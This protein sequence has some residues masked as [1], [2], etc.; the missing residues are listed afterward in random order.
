MLVITRLLK[1]VKVIKRCYMQVTPTLLVQYSY[2]PHSYIIIV[3]PVTFVSG[4]LVII[5]SY[6][7]FS[8][9]SLNQEN[10]LWVYTFSVM[11]EIL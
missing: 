8:I 5:A 9:S 11:S 1:P 7:I 6:F 2:T 3:S 4:E 10:S